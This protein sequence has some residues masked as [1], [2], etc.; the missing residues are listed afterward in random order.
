MRSLVV[1]GRIS[2]T[3]QADEFGQHAAR[4]PNEKMEVIGHECIDVDLET[5]A[6]RSRPDEFFEQMVVAVE[7][8]DVLSVTALVEDVE[9]FR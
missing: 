7:A 9:P 8:E 4:C 1:G 6:P 5:G 2:G 3:Q